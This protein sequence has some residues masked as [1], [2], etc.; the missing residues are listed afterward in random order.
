[1]ENVHRTLLPSIILLGL[2]SIQAEPGSRCNG[3]LV[4]VW[5]TSQ[6][7][8]KD[9]LPQGVPIDFNTSRSRGL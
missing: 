9:T 3:A 8:L 2:G 1:M 4:K 7:S 6:N 5:P